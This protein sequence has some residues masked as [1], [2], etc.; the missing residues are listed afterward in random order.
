MNKKNL[1]IAMIAILIFVGC[2]TE[3]N[4]QI[5]LGAII[6]LTGYSSLNGTLFKKG[7]ELAVDEIN[8]DSSDITFNLTL[9]DC[10]SSPKDALMAYRKIES[11]GIKNFIG[12]GGQFVL[13]FAA[14]T[15]KSD[16]ILFVSAAPNKNMLSLSNR[17]IR[18]FPTIDMITDYVRDFAITNNYSNVAIIYAQNEAYSMYF[19]SAL[20]KLKDAGKNVVFIESYDPNCRDFRNI[21]SKLSQKKVD[22]IYSA[23]VGESSALLTKQIF[24]NPTTSNIPIIGDM[25]FST[26]ENLDIIGEVKSPIYSID[27]YI[28]ESFS[29]KYWAKYHQTPNTYAIYGYVIPYILKDAFLYLGKDATQ[30]DIFTY[31]RTNTFETSAGK[32]SFDLQSGEP[33]LELVVN[34][35]I[36]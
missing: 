18:I 4:T 10:K 19:E 14:E 24:N 33:N 36:K 7:L 15:N 8:Q 16:K 17:I 9:E 25:N 11:K 30:D 6:P 32:I 31:I 27:N 21:V 35:T 26:P 13:G 2:K 34:R 3:K 12:F 1:L 20:K 5:E 29:K 23:G 22:M 28:E